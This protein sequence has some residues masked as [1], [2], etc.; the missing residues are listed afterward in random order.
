[1]SPARFY[2]KYIKNNMFTKMSAV[3][4]LIAVVTIVTL[5]FLMYY[6]LFQSAVRSELDIQRSAVERVER[7]VNQN[8]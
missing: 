6:F 8:I 3:N 2:Q 7:H 4:L 1:M 5:S